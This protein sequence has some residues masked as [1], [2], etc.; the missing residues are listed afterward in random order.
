VTQYDIENPI[1]SARVSRI[2]KAAIDKLA[3]NR[4][5][6]RN[7]V[8]GRLLRDALVDRGVLLVEEKLKEE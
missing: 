7:E 8:I 6:N 1:I 4:K 2:V 3:E 5:E